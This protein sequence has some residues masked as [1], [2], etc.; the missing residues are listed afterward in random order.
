M[1]FPAIDAISTV[2]FVEEV[3]E[4]R[5]KARGLPPIER[6]S[7][8]FA[9]LVGMNDYQVSNPKDR[10]YG[11]LGLVEDINL[12]PEVLPIDYSLTD[13]EVFIAAAKY[14]IEGY[15]RLELL[16]LLRPGQLVLSKYD[17]PSWCPDWTINFNKD[18]VVKASRLLQHALRDAYLPVWES[19][20]KISF[21][22]ERNAMTVAGIA[23]DTIKDIAGEFDWE[24]VH[25][26]QFFALT[27]PGAD[28]T[29]HLADEYSESE[30]ESIRRWCKLSQ[31]SNPALGATLEGTPICSLDFQRSLLREVQNHV[32]C[33]RE[34]SAID[35]RLDAFWRTLMV[36]PSLDHNERTVRC[37]TMFNAFMCWND[38]NIPGNVWD[39][40]FFLE[41]TI[42]FR[43]KVSG[44]A[45][46]RQFFVSN[47]G[48]MGL[49]PYGTKEGDVVCVLLGYGCPVTLRPE[50]DHYLVVGETYIH[51]FMRGEAYKE[52]EN[53]TFVE[54][55]FIL[56]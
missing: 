20:A 31:A 32:P 23:V 36:E 50:G 17:L 25:W 10:I 29:L 43:R 54:E 42:P 12:Q 24:R 34:D 16:S 1:R 5:S 45:H 18:S 47:N 4:Q 3:K 11:L 19:S 6:K 51:G 9:L 28:F 33:L 35:K 49:A 41:F 46:G 26:F 53:G 52:V 39:D 14:I 8:L 55:D 2:T 44:V 30:L 48:N 7:F 40:Q 13:E 21:G 15:G 56:R 38:F 22:P 37:K 27:K